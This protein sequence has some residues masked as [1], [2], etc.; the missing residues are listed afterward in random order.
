MFKGDFTLDD[1]RLQLEQ[2]KQTGIKEVLSSIPGVNGTIP[3]SEDPEK[4]LSRIQGII[5]SMTKEERRNPDLIDVNRCR[6]IAVGSG[7]EAHE[8]K[9]FLAQFD[10]MRAFMKRLAK[11]GPFPPFKMGESEPSDN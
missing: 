3:K 5:D 2:L 11:M 6:R 1:F 7:I 10:Q 8:I 4:F 9:R